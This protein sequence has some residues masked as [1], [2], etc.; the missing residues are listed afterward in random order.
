MPRAYLQQVELQIS[1]FFQPEVHTIHNIMRK[2]LWL[3]SYS[4][5]T[6]NGKS[7]ILPCEDFSITLIWSRVSESIGA[8]CHMIAGPVS[9][10]YCQ[11]ENLCSWLQADV[12]GCQ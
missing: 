7:S 3:K 8:A 12:E 2:V 10:R 6:M 4:T 11:R 9:Y 5:N 1:D